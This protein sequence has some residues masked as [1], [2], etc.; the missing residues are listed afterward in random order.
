MASTK[1]GPW[2]EDGY[3]NKAGRIEQNMGTDEPFL[4]ELMAVRTWQCLNGC[5]SLDWNYENCLVATIRTVA[6]AF[7]LTY[8]LTGIYLIIQSLFFLHWPGGLPLRHLH[9]QPRPARPNASP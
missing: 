6:P 5:V 8:F 7:R 2:Y 4:V 1:N 9:V 3:T